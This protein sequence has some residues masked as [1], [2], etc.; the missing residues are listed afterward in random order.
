MPHSFDNLL[1]RIR[2]ALPGLPGHSNDVQV[3]MAELFGME[4]GVTEKGALCPGCLADSLDAKGLGGKRDLV[5][6]LVLES[7]AG[8]ISSILAD[9][10]KVP[11][12][13]DLP[14]EDD[15]AKLRSGVGRL[16]GKGRE[17]AANVNVVQKA[18]AAAQAFE[19]EREGK[20][21]HLAEL[22]VK[23]ATA[24]GKSEDEAKGFLV[25]IVKAVRGRRERGVTLDDVLVLLVHVYGTMPS[26]AEFYPED[27]DRLQSVFSEAIVQDG[28]RLGAVLRSLAKGMVIDEIL[29]H[30]MVENVFKKLR[31]LPASRSNTAYR[32]ISGGG[33]LAAQLM[34]DIYSDDRRD[35]ADLF[36]HGQ[37]LV[38]KGL[39]LFGV[40]VNRL[41][42]REN[43]TV[44]VI[45]VGGITA[46]EARQIHHIV[47]EKS[48]SVELLVGSTT[49]C[50]PSQTVAA[51]FQKDPLLLGK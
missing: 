44:V 24:L 9:L 51:L 31:C 46:S 37:G 22:Q 48:S 20:L 14:G 16:V 17:I 21:S 45:V 26:G 5:G 29:A 19:S 2:A 15:V 10:E 50:S 32:D 36:H 28:D 40:K 7:E 11:S 35:V 41:H 8:A 1:D 34:R 6:N 4:R 27:E 30:Q 3:E 23:F 33:G 42:P 43:Q 49:L 13:G 18:V 12:V 39:S 47:R 25:E 38:G